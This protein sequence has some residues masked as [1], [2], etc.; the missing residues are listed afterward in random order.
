MKAVYNTYLV[1][2]ASVSW[3]RERVTMYHDFVGPVVALFVPSQLSS[4]RIF[5]VHR[6]LTPH[7][8]RR[9]LYLCLG[10]I[11]PEALWYPCLCSLFFRYIDGEG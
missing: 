1:S 2:L 6:H 8:V 5:E 9:K 7:N 11:V 10:S 4:F 3:T